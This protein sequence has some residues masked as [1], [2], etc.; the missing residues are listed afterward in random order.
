VLL[1][2]A[3][4]AAQRVF[5]R[6]GEGVIFS[7]AN[8]ADIGSIGDNVLW[9]A[10]ATVLIAPNLS[11]WVRGEGG[12]H[13]DGHDWAVLLGVVGAAIALMGR[14]LGLANRIN[15]ENEQIV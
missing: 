2:L 5:A 9:A 3:V 6:M 1:L 4:L 13:F 12:F 11:A 7:A 15:A 8:A 14:V 10:I